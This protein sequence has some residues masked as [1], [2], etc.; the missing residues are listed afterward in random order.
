MIRQTISTKFSHFICLLTL[1]TVVSCS[2]VPLSVDSELL[3]E[4]KP[5]AVHWQNPEIFEENKLPARASF[6]AFENMQHTEQNNIVNS[7]RFMSLNGDWLFYRSQN[8]A[9]HPK[10]FYQLNY[11]LNAFKTIRVPGSPEFAGEGTPY[12][13]NIDYVFP[14]NQPFVPTDYNPVNAYVKFVELDRKWQNMRT[15]LHIGGI[16]SAAYVWVNG[17]YVGY[18]QGAK[19][20]AEFDI[21]AFLTKGKNKIAIENI[22]WSDGSYLEDQDGWNTSGIER[23]V[24]LYATPNTHIH[25]ISVNASLD[26]TYKTGE[27]SV[28][29]DLTKSALSENVRLSAK[30]VD[31]EQVI[32]TGALL[33]N[34]QN[35]YTFSTSIPMVRKWSAESPHL[36]DLIISMENTDTNEGE[37]IKIPVGFR[38]LE[39]VGGV[40]KVNGEMVTIR[41]V[42]RVE[43]HMYGGRVVT[44]ADML[45]DVQLMKSFNINALRMAHFPNDP[46]IYELAD[47]YGLYVMDEANIESHKYMQLGNQNKDQEKYHLGFQPE[48]EAAHLS[49]ITRM[50]ERDKN[51]PSIIFWS[52]GNE[53]GLGQ[54]FEKGAQAIRKLDPS[55]PVTYGGW[56]TVNGHSVL[57]YVDIYTP[58]YDSIGELEDYIAANP[59]QPLIMA[60]YAHAMGNSLGNLDKY[61]QAIY[62]NRQLQGGFI[63]DWVDQTILLETPQGQKYWGYGGDFNDQNNDGNF[64]ANGLIQADRTPNPHLYEAKKVYQPIHFSLT[65]ISNFTVSVTNKY[66]FLDLSH[67]NFYWR[68]ER[69]GEPIASSHLD[70]LDNT[71]PNQSSSIAMD[72]RHLVKDGSGDYQVTIYA[73]DMRKMERANIPNVVDDGSHVKKMRNSQDI[74]DHVAAWEQFALQSQIQNGPLTASNSK[75]S[76]ALNINQKTG[77]IVVTGSDFSLVFDKSTGLIEDYQYQQTAMLTE[78]PSLNFWRLPT[79]NDRGWSMHNRNSIWRTASMKQTLVSF[80]VAKVDPNNVVITALYNI[81][82]DVAQTTIQWHVNSQGR[83]QAKVHFL[84]TSAKLPLMPRIGLH[85]S[86]PENMKSLAWYGRGPHENYVDRKT[87]AAVGLYTSTVSEQLHDYSRL[88][89]SGNKTDT[90]W[91]TVVNSGGIGWRFTS[92]DVFQFSALQGD[93]YHLYPEKNH[94]R[95]VSAINYPNSNVVRLDYLHMGVGGDD[96]WGAKPHKEFLVRPQEYSFSFVMEPINE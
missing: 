82:N 84:P 19:L 66:N 14:E 45:K 34:E 76:S 37:Y 88:Q 35:Q 53:A 25:D 16:N 54:A 92:D 61:W 95:H 79:D 50:V 26:N 29:L 1:A 77:S 91:F 31:K 41:G 32:H 93:K 4:P 67:L 21:S 59:N 8:P 17:E 46:Y 63:W 90:H 13:K 38:K 96:S 87:S 58:M 49:R 48:W 73:I 75:P 12:Y 9:Q 36:Y 57:D 72:L 68:L 30:L 27:L 11:K 15:V 43:H 80:D 18:T 89:E 56:G 55:R 51:H 28:A 44:K 94:P 22:R 39:L 40:F 86:I 20:P 2:N 69:N 24:Y 60:E 70:G 52:M 83:I 62:A 5:V 33:L 64:L 78:A 23:N 81:A 6:F 10:D 3:V 42:N 7:S 47:K 65:D 85:M 74:H 71:K